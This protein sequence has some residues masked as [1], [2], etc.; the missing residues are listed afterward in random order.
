MPRMSNCQ[1]AMFRPSGLQRKPSRNPNSSSYTQSLIPLTSVCEAS[2]VRRVAGPP[3]AASTYR[4]PLSTYATRDP[5]GL[6]LANISLD[7]GTWAPPTWCNR[8]VVRSSIQ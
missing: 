7:S 4:S 8:F 6:N 2:C 1:K 5:S 3:P